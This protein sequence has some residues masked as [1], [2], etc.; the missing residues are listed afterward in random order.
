MDRATLEVFAETIEHLLNARARV[1]P[2]ADRSYAELLERA[3]RKVDEIAPLN[4]SRR[5]QDAADGLGLGDLRRFCWFCSPLSKHKVQRKRLFVW[6]HYE[7]V[8]QM[9]S[10]IERL[11]PPRGPAEIVAILERTKIVWIHRDEDDSL[12]EKDLKSVRPDAASAYRSADIHL[13]HQW[14]ECTTSICQG[15]GRY[16][17][18]PL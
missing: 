18:R 7:P 12:N 14:D 16:Q 8:T 15:H 1:R 6:E 5:A 11:E 4:V 13:V 3:I 9:R 17:R 10:A 2:P